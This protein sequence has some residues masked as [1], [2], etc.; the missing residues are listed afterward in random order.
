MRGRPGGQMAGGEQQMLTIARTLMG[1]PRR[2][3]WTSRPRAWRPVIVEMMAQAIIGHEGGGQSIVAARSRT[4]HFAAAV[5]DR[6]YV[7]EKG[8]IRFEGTMAA[9]REDEEMR[10]TYLSL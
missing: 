3:C 8:R 10:S 5:S 2:C 6:A 4:S 1:N 9:L 7:I